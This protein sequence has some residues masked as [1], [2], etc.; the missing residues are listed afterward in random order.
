MSLASLPVSE[1]IRS[2]LLD[3]ADSRA[4]ELGQRKTLRFNRVSS[5]VVLAWLLTAGVLLSAQ[6]STVDFAQFYMAGAIGCAGAWESL[7]PIPNPDSRHNPG[8]ARDSAM[9]PAYADLASSL[10][11]GNTMRYIQAPP[12]AL[13]YLP[14]GLLPY[15][16]AQVLWGALNGA[17]LWLTAILAASLFAMA[18]GRRSRWEGV[19]ILVIGLSPRSVDTIHWGNVSAMN[20]ALIGLSAL[21]Y[22]RE[23]SGRTGV[24]LAVGAFLKYASGALLPIVVAGRRWRILI[25]AAAVLVIWSALSLIIMGPAPFRVFANEI[26][27]TLSRPYFNTLI[28]MSMSTMVPCRAPWLGGATAVLVLKYAILGWI[29]I[30]LFSTRARVWHRPVPFC[31]GSVALLSWFMLFSPV[32]WGHYCVYL[33]PFWGW[34]LWEAIHSR[35]QATAAVVAAFLALV[36]WHQVLQRA[37]MPYPPILRFG[38]FWSV[39]IIWG[40]AML[41]LHRLR[42]AERRPAL[43]SL[44]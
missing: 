28:S 30:L 22:L 36:P 7:Y 4:A 14:V 44:R 43:P 29:L 42:H 26:A 17:S 6:R 32:L 37:A 41:R 12:T 27:P 16:T 18:L 3:A 20:G 39:W 2:F 34:M 23:M 11:V 21:A 13:L 25:W 40:M 24:A 1:E 9:R 15:K 33:F 38:V 10:G 19:L 31:A 35:I 5:A 8:L